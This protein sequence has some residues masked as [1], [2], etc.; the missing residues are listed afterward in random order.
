[1]AAAVRIYMLSCEARSATREATLARLGG[2]DWGD[3]VSVV[4]DPTAEGRG[5]DRQEQASRR[6]LE[7]AVADGAEVVLFLE[8]DL[9][10]NRHL[11]HNLGSWHPLQSMAADGHFFASL[12]GPNVR[13]LWRDDDRHYYVAE[14][15]CVYGSQAF[16]LSAETVR[17]ALSHWDEVPGMQDIKMSRL[18]ARVTPIYYHVPS[19][20]QHVGTQSTWGGPFHWAPDFS[21]DWRAPELPHPD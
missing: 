7:Q 9:D 20:V 15:E 17:W 2:T 12:Y 5:Q 14:P 19:L 16:L 18:A 4:L 11:G 8:D 3:A 21:A 6:L 1:M 13:A 10:F